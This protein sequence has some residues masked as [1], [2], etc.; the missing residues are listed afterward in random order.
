VSTGPIFFSQLESAGAGVSFAF[1]NSAPMYRD[2]EK[3][4]YSNPRPIQEVLQNNYKLP[5]GEDRRIS[6]LEAYFEHS[7]ERL[8]Q[9]FKRAQGQMSLVGPRPV[10]PS[11]LNMYGDYGA[12]F[13]W[14]K[15]G[16]P[17]MQVNGRSDVEDYSRRAALEFGICPDPIAEN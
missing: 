8:P 2:A 3:T 11:E 7:L 4:L 16:L 6:R 15:P 1:I 9:L 12:L 13:M 14:V 17:E 10:V 5:K